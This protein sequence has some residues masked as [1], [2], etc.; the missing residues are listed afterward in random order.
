MEQGASEGPNVD[1]VFLSDTDDRTLR[2]FFLPTVVATSLYHVAVHHRDLSSAL[3]TLLTLTAGAQFNI[4]T[5]LVAPGENHGENVWE[6]VLEYQGD[7]VSS[8][9]ARSAK[10]DAAW[11]TKSALP[12]LRDKLAAVVDDPAFVGSFDFSLSAPTYPRPKTTV[13]RLPLLSDDAV[14]TMGAGPPSGEVDPVAEIELRRRAIASLPSDEHGVR[15]SIL[16]RIGQRRVW[17]TIFL[18]YTTEGEAQA[19]KIKSRLSEHYDVRD[20]NADLT[21]ESRERAVEITSSDHFIGLWHHDKR[22]PQGPGTFGGS[23][24]VHYHQGLAIASGKQ[25]LTVRS[26]DADPRFWPGAP[27]A[28]HIIY[29]DLDFSSETLGEIEEYCRDHFVRD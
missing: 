16:E 8:Q 24:W 5:S 29:W 23:P 18:A 7:D 14:A 6:A 11:F 21:P 17:P 27:G 25:T 9:P 10:S 19:K 28:D 3:G 4:L 15:Y 1:Y 22:A 2:V 12:W 20:R 13:Q 26:A